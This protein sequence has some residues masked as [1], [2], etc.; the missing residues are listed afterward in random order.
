MLVTGTGPVDAPQTV[1]AVVAAPFAKE[2][3]LRQARIDQLFQVA[4]EDIIDLASVGASWDMLQDPMRMQSFKETTMGAASRLSVNRLGVLLNAWKRWKKFCRS[5]DY[6]YQMP[7]PVQTAEFLR[8]CIWDACLSQMVC[9]ESWS[10]FPDGALD[11]CPL[12]FSC[13]SP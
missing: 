4:L 7:T 11:E 10:R 5:L 13:C 3:A 6:N 9:S 1:G 8:D 2:E 12:P